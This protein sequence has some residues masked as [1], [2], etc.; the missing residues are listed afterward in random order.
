MDIISDATS[1]WGE[2][3]PL[4]Q[5]MVHCAACRAQYSRL[6]ALAQDLKHLSAASIQISPGFHRRWVAKITSDAQANSHPTITSLALKWLNLLPA[7]FRPALALSPIWLAI[8]LFKISTPQPSRLELQPVGRSPIEV[9]QAFITSREPYT[10]LI[11]KPGAAENSRRPSATSP[12]PSPSP[13]TDSSNEASLRH[14]I[15]IARDGLSRSS[16]RFRSQFQTLRTSDFELLSSHSYD[17]PQ[18]S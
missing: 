7:Q 11:S 16:S 18:P 15:L 8:L 4:K 1:G 14:S 10:D 9:F 3:E 5:H 13:K 12:G 17:S 2:N 6:Q